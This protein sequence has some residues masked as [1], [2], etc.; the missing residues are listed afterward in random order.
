MQPW[1][2]Q[3]YFICLSTIGK[4]FKIS[5]DCLAT[6]RMSNKYGALI[7]RTGKIGECF[8]PGLNFRFIWMWHEWNMHFIFECLKFAFCQRKPTFLR[9]AVPPMYDKCLFF[10]DVGLVTSAVPFDCRSSMT[11]LIGFCSSGFSTVGS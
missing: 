4:S 11:E 1:R 7:W 6:D 3:N 2:N 9:I 10:H 8:N 5:K